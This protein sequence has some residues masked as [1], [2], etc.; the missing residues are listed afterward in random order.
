MSEHD[1]GWE[2]VNRTDARRK[3]RALVPRRRKKEE[4]VFGLLNSEEGGMHCVC[5]RMLEPHG[6]IYGEMAYLIRH[7][8]LNCSLVAISIG[9]S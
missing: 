2:L 8:R 6:E 4:L 1:S 3:G 9:N 5:T 7:G